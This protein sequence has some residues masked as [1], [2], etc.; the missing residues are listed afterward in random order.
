MQKAPVACLVAQRMPHDLPS[1]K[2]CCESACL[3]ASPL[4][5]D[6]CVLDATKEQS[7]LPARVLA[8][9]LTHPFL[10]R[11]ARERQSGVQNVLFPKGGAYLIANSSLYEAQ[12]RKIRAHKNKIGASTPSLLKSPEP[13]LKGE[14][15]W[16]WGFFSRKNQKIPGAHKIGA[17]ISGLRIAGG[18]ILD[19]RIFLT[20]PEE[21]FS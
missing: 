13:P 1:Q 16:A 5:E 15:L 14:I 11:N 6:V 21:I 7:T 20:N 10:L 3:A 18:K 12:F 4:H 9:F 19:M 2:Q 17:A 8:S